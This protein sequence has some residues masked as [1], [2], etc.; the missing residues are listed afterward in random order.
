M[1]GKYM[2]L[3]SQYCIVSHLESTAHTVNTLNMNSIVMND[4]TTVS[5]LSNIGLIIGVHMTRLGHNWV[6]LLHTGLSHVSGV[7]L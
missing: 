6:S 1:A 5:I 7:T 4:I 2:Y 3:I